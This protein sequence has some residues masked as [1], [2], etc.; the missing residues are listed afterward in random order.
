MAGRPS[1]TLLKFMEA[2]KI[3][4]DE[5]W[6]VRTG[7]AWA[8]KHAALERV[9]TEQGITFSPP[10]VIEA[11][12]TDKVVALCVTAKMGERTDWSIGEAAPGNNKNNYPFAM[13]EKR[14][15]DRCVLKLLNS[16]GALYSEAEADE[17][18]RSNPHTTKPEDIFEPTEHDQ[19]GQPIDN[20]PNGDPNIKPLPKKN[21]KEIFT[22][23]QS[24]IRA[25][26]TIEELEHWAG[27][28]K[29]RVAQ[30]QPDWREII[31]GVYADKRDEIRSKIGM[32]KF[33]NG[34]NHAV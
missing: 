20:I 17:F 32:N 24:E 5:V 31:R 3:D 6:E 12:G 25:C 1:P 9:A 30:F 4:A 16:H 18:V 23:C 33:R 28:N 19:N 21:A 7:G 15:K 26:L 27:L 11:S 14:A 13:A 22:A 8:I 2:Y 10:T 34:D 29:D